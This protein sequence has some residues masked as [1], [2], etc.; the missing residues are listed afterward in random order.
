[1]VGEEE[2]GTKKAYLGSMERTDSC[3]FAENSAYSWIASRLMADGMRWCNFQGILLIQR[4]SMTIS[5]VSRWIKR[6]QKNE[7]VRDMTK[8]I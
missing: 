3:F 1:M 8:H 6:Q 7:L 5:K 4:Y 2:M